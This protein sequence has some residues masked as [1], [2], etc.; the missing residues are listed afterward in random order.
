MTQKPLVSIVV[1]IY[2]MERFL[3]ETLQSIAGTRYE[4]LEVILVDDGS[5]DKSAQI[6][7]SFVSKDPR[8]KLISQEN[9]GVS[10]ARN[11]GIEKAAGKYILPV[12]ADNIIEPTFVERAVTAFENGGDDVVVVRPRIV[13]FG[14]QTGEW[15]LT[16]LSGS[17][18]YHR[19]LCFVQEERLVTCRWLL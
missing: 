1:P 8:F 4:P 11:Q 5:K 6:A 13:F 12:D 7:Q 2:N 14:D 17:A 19:Q 18:K 10:H 15:E 16:P 3:E 9:A